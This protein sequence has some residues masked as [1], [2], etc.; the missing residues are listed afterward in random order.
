MQSQSVA[1]CP[2]CGT[3]TLT[4]HRLSLRYSSCCG[5]CLCTDC[6]DTLFASAASLSSASASAA[7]SSSSSSASLPCPSCSAS[8][9]VK[10]FDPQPLSTQRYTKEVKLRQRLNRQLLLTRDDFESEAEWCDWEEWKAEVVWELT[11]GDR[12]EQKEAERKVE[13][14]RRSN[15]HRIDAALERRRQQDR[16]Q[17]LQAAG[18]LDDD[19][20]A[21]V[22]GLSSVPLIPSF[23]LPSAT[24]Q[25]SLLHELDAAIARTEDAEERA[26]KKEERHAVWLRGR[27]SG[28]WTDQFADIR[29]QEEMLEGWLMT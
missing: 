23:P 25:P 27:R 17:Q 5:L 15:Q 21:A 4:N 2:Q 7:A 18:G 22:A 24:L 1:S 10:E 20:A 14:W 13:E 28:G 19:E 12:E 6:I 11:E 26:R 3:T 16:R 29:E 8:L 9:S